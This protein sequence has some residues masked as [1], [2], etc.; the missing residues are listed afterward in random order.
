MELCSSINGSAIS[1]KDRDAML[2]CIKKVKFILDITVTLLFFTFLT[3][4]ER[5]RRKVEYNELS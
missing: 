2:T 5:L 1:S 3:A 4:D